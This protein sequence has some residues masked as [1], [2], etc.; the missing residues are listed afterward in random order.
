M[1]DTL[2]HKNVGPNVLSETLALH[3]YVYIYIYVYMYIV[4]LVV[5]HRGQLPRTDIGPGYGVYGVFA[6]YNAAE[7]PKTALVWDTKANVP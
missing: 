6:S 7:T 3:V 2:G 4:R 1:A 5:D